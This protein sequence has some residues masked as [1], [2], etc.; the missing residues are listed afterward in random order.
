MKNSSL[1][2]IQSSEHCV[3]FHIMTVNNK[4]SLLMS[5]PSDKRSSAGRLCFVKRTVQII[6]FIWRQHNGVIYIRIRYCNPAAKSLFF[7]YKISISRIFF[8][9]SVQTSVVLFSSS[10]IVDESFQKFP[11]LFFL[12]AIPLPLLMKNK[13]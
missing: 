11:V 8:I 3:V 4:T 2:K 13:Y 6:W 10:I 1:H 12:A 5:P 7:S 9:L